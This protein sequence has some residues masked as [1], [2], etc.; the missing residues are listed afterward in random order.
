MDRKAEEQGET[1]S[2]QDSKRKE[3]VTGVGAMGMR[4]RAEI[5]QKEVLDGQGRIV[6]EEGID[7]Q[8]S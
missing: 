6:N 4:R 3:G 2:E 5:R 7:E 8:G 1:G